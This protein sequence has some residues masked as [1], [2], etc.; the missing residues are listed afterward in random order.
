MLVHT[1]GLVLGKVNDFIPDAFI[2]SHDK[3]LNGAADV[4][5]LAKPVSLTVPWGVGRL[6]Y[7]APR[8][9]ANSRAKAPGRRPPAKTPDST[10]LPPPPSL[11]KRSQ[12]QV[13]PP[14]RMAGPRGRC[15]IK[16]STLPQASAA[17]LFSHLA[18]PP[19]PLRRL[20][21]GAHRP[22]RFGRGIPLLPTGCTP[23]VIRCQKPFVQHTCQTCTV[24]TR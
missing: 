6:G 15:Q 16:G 20:P 13:V 14:S 8:G 2:E 23:R 21:R 1:I 18:T 4:E 24:A 10:H 19:P 12:A 11:P 5:L 22:V 9:G 7:S 17:F 3:R